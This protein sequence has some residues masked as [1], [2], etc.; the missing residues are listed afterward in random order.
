WR[1]AAS[2]SSGVIC[3]LAINEARPTASYLSYSAASPDR[4]PSAIPAPATAALLIISRRSIF[5][6]ELLR[7]RGS[8][9]TALYVYK[10]E[11]QTMPFFLAETCLGCT[12][13]ILCPRSGGR[14]L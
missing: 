6:R 9:D 11:T 7:K 10:L 3:F 8:L 2:N 13:C 14:L 5:I 12:R 1:T 4:F